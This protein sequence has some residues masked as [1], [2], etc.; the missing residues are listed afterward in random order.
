M[1]AV[2]HEATPP[3]APWIRSLDVGAKEGEMIRTCWELT[4]KSLFG[5]KFFFCKWKVKVCREFKVVK[6]WTSSW[7]SGFRIRFI[8]SLDSD[9]ETGWINQLLESLDKIVQRLKTFRHSVCITST[10]RMVIRTW[11][12]NQDSDDTSL[13]TTIKWFGPLFNLGLKLAFFCGLTEARFH[14]IYWCWCL[15]F[16]SQN[17]FSLC[18]HLPRGQLSDP[19]A[20]REW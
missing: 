11:P 18:S 4:Y 8:I 16:S 12:Q 15:F 14:A 13:T 9:W 17:P 6:Y 3:S 2:G 10:G 1:W 5:K 7:L 20:R 19:Y